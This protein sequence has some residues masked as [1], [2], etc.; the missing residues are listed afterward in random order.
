MRS[1]A[2]RSR[3]LARG[4]LSAVGLATAVLTALSGC[5]RPSTPTSNAPSA[6]GPPAAANGSAAA[7]ASTPA[8]GKALRV[9]ASNA[10]LAYF[11]KRLGDD[12]VEVSMPAPDHVDPA[13]WTPKSSEISAMQ[14]ADLI[15]LN[16]AGFEKWR[17]QVALPERK[18][19][20]TAD[21]FRSAWIETHDGV[22]HSHGTEGQHSHAGTV[23]TTWIDPMQAI[24]Q[25]R[26][27]HARLTELLPDRKESLQNNFQALERDLRDI[28]GKLEMAVGSQ[29][30]LPILYSH[31][32]YDYLTRRF[33][34]NARS[35]QWE[36]E[37]MP[38]AE[39]LER[40]A[41]ML[42]EHPAKWMLWE[43]EPGGAIRAKL[44]EL[45]VECAVFAPASNMGTD[46]GR[47]LERQVENTREFARI[48]E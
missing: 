39:E 27:I 17:S 14:A 24:E 44:R 43:D 1:P 11:T 13:F 7:G 23:F 46:W 34:L 37:E 47:W 28:D 5:D 32:I 12:A 40:L 38:P 26:A 3:R 36:P 30:G 41:A 31:P 42:K 18:V 4:L 22:T 29:H 8:A 19:I 9:I 10:P 21:G 2:L 35:V 33:E 6:S 16:G 15:V 20:E 45:G 25:A 48:F